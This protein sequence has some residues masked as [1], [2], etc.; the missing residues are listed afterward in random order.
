MFA[1]TVGRFLFLVQASTSL[2]LIIFLSSV[3]CYYLSSEVCQPAHLIFW[4]LH[5][6]KSCQWLIE[7]VLLDGWSALMHW[8]FE[9]ESVEML[10]V[11]VCNLCQWCHL[12]K[13]TFEKCK[14]FNKMQ[15]IRI[16]I[17][18]HLCLWRLTFNSRYTFYHFFSLGITPMTYMLYCL[19]YRK[20]KQDE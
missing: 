3:L 9:C 4:S 5:H 2:F 8:C 6:D 10:Q 17:N 7:R 16:W 18:L 1:W 19:S 12:K 13:H 20:A 11:T 15:W 14:L